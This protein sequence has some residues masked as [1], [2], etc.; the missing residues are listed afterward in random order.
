MNAKW[1]KLAVCARLNW[2]KKIQLEKQNR[3]YFV[4]ALL[5]AGR[6]CPASY[7]TSLWCRQLKIIK[8]SCEINIF[9]CLPS[10][11]S[12]LLL[13]E[14]V[15]LA[16]DWLR[17]V[18][19]FVEPT[20]SDKRKKNQMI[21]SNSRKFRKTPRQKQKANLTKNRAGLVAIVF[22]RIS[23]FLNLETPF[24]ASFLL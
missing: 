17:V 12:W 3:T 22:E 20:M 1:M 5:L 14:R 15:A 18:G 19:R 8:E 24:L 6:S 9:K 16:L 7:S 2:E 4:Q 21:R 23:M 10:F 11:E 13:F